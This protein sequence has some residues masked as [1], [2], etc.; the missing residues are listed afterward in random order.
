MGH[1]RYH[2]LLVLDC[3]CVCQ[4]PRRRCG[5]LQVPGPKRTRLWRPQPVPCVHSLDSVAVEALSVPLVVTWRTV[6]VASVTQA[7][8]VP[9][10]S[11]TAHSPSGRNLLNGAAETTAVHIKGAQRT[12]PQG[13]RR[14][15]PN[16]HLLDGAK[17]VVEASTVHLL[18]GACRSPGWGSRGSRGCGRA[19]E[20]ERRRQRRLQP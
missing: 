10:C 19:L 4:Q 9:H 7:L 1:E 2:L 15:V 5:V 18:D 20:A 17:V 11:G 8:A 14:E 16:P 13:A 6:P 3:P 12:V